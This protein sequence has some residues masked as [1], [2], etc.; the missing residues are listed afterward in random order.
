[1]V[2]GSARNDLIA[3]TEGSDA[4]LL[5][6]PHMSP[7]QPRGRLSGVEEIDGRGGNDLIDLSSYTTLGYLPVGF[8][9]MVVSGGRGN[10]TLVGNGRNYCDLYGGEDNDHL[11]ASHGWEVI[12]GRPGWD[13]SH[14]FASR[15]LVVN[16]DDRRTY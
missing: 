12:D 2:H 3:L 4:L 1:V 11:W 7:T 15:F 10:D 16:I 6:D 8:D 9:G 13:V 5:D 14:V